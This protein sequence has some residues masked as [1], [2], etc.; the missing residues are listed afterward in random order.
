[1]STSWV[2]TLK[3]DLKVD[4]GIKYEIYK[5]HLGFPTFGIGHLILS[6]DP[7]SKQDVGTKVPK[8]R[9]EA[10]FDS[11]LQKTLDDCR[12]LFADFEE[13]PDEAKIVIGNMMFNLGFSKLSN[14][15]NFGEAV[16]NRDWNKA[17]E[18]MK[19]S[20]WYRQVTKRAERLIARIKKL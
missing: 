20:L 11:D 5:D 8:E 14:F 3:S 12:K 15:K 7:E 4:E 1:M 10:V 13:L 17:A 2:N 9:V 6:S 18:E 19:N 16:R